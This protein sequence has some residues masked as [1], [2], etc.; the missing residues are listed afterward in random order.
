[1]KKVYCFNYIKMYFYIFGFMV[2]I[3][4]KIYVINVYVFF[5]L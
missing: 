2:F 3:S 4:N 5:E 1:M